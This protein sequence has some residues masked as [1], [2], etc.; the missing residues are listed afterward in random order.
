MEEKQMNS[1]SETYER[2]IHKFLLHPTSPNGRE[3]TYENHIESILTNVN[4]TSKP[5]DLTTS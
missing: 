2:M 3:K 4:P 1:D 5:D